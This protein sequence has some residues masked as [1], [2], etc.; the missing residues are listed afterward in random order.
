M[1]VRRASWPHQ[2]EHRRQREERRNNEPPKARHRPTLSLAGRAVNVACPGSSAI[3]AAV[4]RSPAHGDDRFHSLG[5]R[6]VSDVPWSRRA[7]AETTLTPQVDSDHQTATTSRSGGL[8]RRLRPPVS[9][10]TACRSSVSTTFRRIMSCGPGLSSWRLHRTDP[11]GSLSSKRR[12]G[13]RRARSRLHSRSLP[14]RMPSFTSS[15]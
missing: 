7:I 10:T 4:M 3:S 9:T 13:W 1:V 14:G 6:A 8:T 5:R 15:L 12:Y 11:L 2:Q